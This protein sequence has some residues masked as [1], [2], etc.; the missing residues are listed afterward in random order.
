MRGNR[1]CARLERGKGDRHLLPERPDQ[2]SSGARPSLGARCFAQKVPV[3]FSLFG[4]HVPEAEVAFPDRTSLR[5]LP[6]RAEN[7]TENSAPE[8]RGRFDRGAIA[9][10]ETVQR[11]RPF[12][13]AGRA[14]SARGGPRTQLVKSQRI[15]NSFLTVLDV[16]RILARL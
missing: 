4:Y 8:T 3:P 14:T 11:L 9:Q 7:D 10:P 6:S 15:E 1:A 2:P 13:P 16:D 12:F 5:R